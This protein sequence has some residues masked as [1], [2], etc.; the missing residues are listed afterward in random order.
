MKRLARLLG[1]ALLTLVLSTHG[2]AQS[3]T[4]PDPVGAGFSPERLAR[5]APWYRSQ[6]DTGGLPG[7]VVAIAR[8]GK[9]AYLQAIGTYDRAGKI[10]LK[11][12]AIFWAAS[13][14]KPVTSVAAMMLVEEGKLDLAAPVAKYLPE[15]KDMRVGLEKAPAKQPMQVIDLLRHTAGLTYGEEG[16]DE[17]HKTYYGLTTFRRDR[18]LAD[19]VTDLARMPLLH[20]PGEVWEY[21]LGVD[22]LA[23]VVE[24]ASG[25]PFDQ[26]LDSRIF[27]PLRMVDTGFFVPEEKLP[28][29]VD[30][31][32]G[33]WPR[34]WDVAKPTTF[35][36][37]GG[38]LVSTAPDYLRFCQML[39]NGGELDGARILSAKTVQQMTTNTLPPEM[40]FAGTVG[41]FVGPRVG[42]G[43]GLGF[44]VR[45]NPEFSILPGAVGSFNWSGIWGQYFWID[46]VEKLIGVQMLQVPPDS[47]APYRDAFRH[48]TYAALSVPPSDEP[49]MPAVVSADILNS[50]VG[51]YDFGA[52]LSSRDKQA[53]FPAL[54][55]SGVGLEVA[56]RD[57]KVTV[58]WPIEGGPAEKAGVK[59]GDVIT[60]IDDVAMKGLALNQ[61]LDKLRGR[62]GTTV[63][64]RIV[65]KDQDS[66]I[67]VTIVREPIRLPG[68]RIQVRVE[69]G[70]LEV[71]ATGRWSVLDFEKDK[72]VAVGATSNTEFRVESGDHTRLAFVSDS[73]G[74]VT[75][76]VLN[77]G[78][79]EIRAEKIN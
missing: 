15:L 79:W 6:I 2:F 16:T 75:G 34:I 8:D 22:V 39:L 46:P 26:F 73:T 7:A 65:R 12:D 32:P 4:T 66:P 29:L 38:G 71:A 3:L 33:G 52:S 70:R 5:I 49:S 31:V 20:Q 63:R 53:P 76:V 43:W 17:L 41:Q 9:L 67:D 23:R 74:K 60:E 1:A 19:F 78:P 62:A 40:R 45:T 50:Y 18:T 54:V 64:L 69:G 13:M 28:R 11:S 59:A 56:V 58:R 35:F 30:P 48:L 55:F 36:S 44:A 37:G 14:T 72:P 24:V 21:S 27:K 77:P 61:V 47:G 51:T 10:P 68:A 25:Q 57:D 42:T